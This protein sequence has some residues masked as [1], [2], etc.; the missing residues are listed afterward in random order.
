MSSNN[1]CMM[2]YENW[3][4]LRELQRRSIIQRD[5]KEGISLL[6]LGF[7]IMFLLHSFFLT[8]FTCVYFSL[9]LSFLEYWCDCWLLYVPRPLGNQCVLN[10]FEMTRERDVNY[11]YDWM[12]S[13][14][15]HFRVGGQLPSACSSKT[16]KIIFK[17]FEFL[18]HMKLVYLTLCFWRKQ[19]VTATSRNSSTATVASWKKKIFH[20]AQQPMLRTC[21]HLI[22]KMWPNL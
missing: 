21:C 14:G 8:L 15:W 16:I 5:R 22:T 11:Y 7:S 1:K 2:K 9:S 18:V 13:E 4:V 3:S 17:R 6:T 10:T 20:S 19:Q 12:C